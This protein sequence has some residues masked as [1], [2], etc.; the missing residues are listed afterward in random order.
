[1]IN[2]NDFNHGLVEKKQ[3]LSLV[4]HQTLHF[5]I[6]T[7]GTKIYSSKVFQTTNSEIEIFWSFFLIYFVRGALFSL[8]SCTTS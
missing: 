6:S 7:Y 4:V 5:Q 8:F 3:S 2:V 1:M